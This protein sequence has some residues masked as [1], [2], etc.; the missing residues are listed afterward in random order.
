[1]LMLMQELLAFA[2]QADKEKAASTAAFRN[3]EVLFLAETGDGD[4]H[5]GNP[6]R[7]SDCEQPQYQDTGCQLFGASS[8]PGHQVPYA[9]LK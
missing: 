6:E 9:L 3:Y 1:M 2:N 5:V 4:H 8:D 7:S